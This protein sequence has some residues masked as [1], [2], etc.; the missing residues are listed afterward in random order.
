MF[1]WIAESVKQVF[2]KAVQIEEQ[3]AEASRLNERQLGEYLLPHLKL[4]L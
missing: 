1:S 4:K 3:A 2:R